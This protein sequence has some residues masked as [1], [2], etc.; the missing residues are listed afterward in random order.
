MRFDSTWISK[1]SH[2]FVCISIDFEFDKFDCIYTKFECNTFELHFLIMRLN[3]ALAKFQS[4]LWQKLKM[5]SAQ[6]LITDWICGLDRL[7]LCKCEM[8][9]CYCCEHVSVCVFVCMYTLQLTGFYAIFSK[10]KTITFVV[11]C[12]VCGSFKWLVETY[13][14]DSSIECS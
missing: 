6:K 11:L 14:I 13:A 9:T 8:L 5:C 3:I 12:C 4:N 1:Q 2:F 7:R 10:K